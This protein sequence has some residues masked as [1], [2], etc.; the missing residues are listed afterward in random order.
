M[1]NSNLRSMHCFSCLIPFD[2]T[3]IN[4]T[5]TTTGTTTTTSGTSSGQYYACPKCKQEFCVD[6]DI[7]IHEVLHNCPGCWS[8]ASESQDNN[9]N[10]NS[11]SNN[12]NKK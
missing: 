3:D 10:N 5:T 7:F 9:N 12:K 4:A 2:K 11:N 8:I 6:C 1:A